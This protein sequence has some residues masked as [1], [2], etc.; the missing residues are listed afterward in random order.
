MRDLSISF[1]GVPCENPFFLGSSCI[2]GTEEMC[3]RAL[4][5]GRRLGRVMVLSEDGAERISS[6][7]RLPRLLP[8]AD[9]PSSK[10]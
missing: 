8:S 2:S 7:A 3:A 10:G 6:T 4:E 9:R 5:A 1:C